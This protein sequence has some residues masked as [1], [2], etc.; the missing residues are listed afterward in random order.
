[1]QSET[2]CYLCDVIVLT[3][4]WTNNYVAGDIKWGVLL[5][6]WRHRNVDLVIYA[7][8][9][10]TGHTQV[11][12]TGVWGSETWLY[13]P[14]IRCHGD[15]PY[16]KHVILQWRHNDHDG[17]SIHQPHGCLLKRLYRR[18]SKKTSTLRVAGLCEGNSPH[19]GPVTRKMFPFDDVILTKCIDVYQYR[20]A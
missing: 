17:V 4:C 6:M 16:L 10:K 7:T 5:F 20:E 1:M 8:H 11:S 12:S 13:S 15:I 19:K 9:S 14:S 3:N 18:W 2:P